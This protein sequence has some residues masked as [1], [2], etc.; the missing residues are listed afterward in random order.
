VSI[1]EPCV[2]FRLYLNEDKLGKVIRPSEPALIRT[3]SH[4]FLRLLAVLVTALTVAVALFAWRIASGPL[5]LDWLTPYVADALSSDDGRIRVAIGGTEL[6]L[7]DDI[8][9]V[10]L[11]VVDVRVTGE[12]GRPA[13]RLP[14]IEIALSLRA[15]LG[16]MV[17][18]ARLEATSPHLVLI[19]RDDGSIGL[20]G[21]EADEASGQVDM[22][23][24]ARQMLG[25]DPNDRAS[26]FEE[27]RIFGGSLT[28]VDQRT[29]HRL[30]A[31][32]AE[33]VL[34]RHQGGL[35]GSL[36]F[37]LLQSAQ[38][39]DVRLAGRYDAATEWID[40]GLDADRVMPSHFASLLPD[41]PLRGVAL[42]L[43]GRL[44]GRLKLDGERS[45][46]RFELAGGPG[47]VDLPDV[48]LAS[49]PIAAARADGEL[50]SDFESVVLNRFEVSAKDASLAGTGTLSWPE[51]QI[52]LD[53]E[54][55]ARNVAA[56]DLALFW[57][58]AAGDEARAWVIE[59][60]TDGIVPQAQAT[61][62]IR[63][64]DLDQRPVPESIVSG[65][66]EYD[67]LTVHYFEE[68]PPLTAVDGSAT[69]TARR[70]DFAVAGGRIGD[71]QV[72]DGSVVITGMG[73]PGRE[74]TQLEVATHAKGS[75]RD[76][77]T[78]IDHP[79][80]GF[81]AEA[82][83]S[84]ADVAGNA[85]IDLRIGLP[86]HRDVEDSEVRVAASAQL[87]GAALQGP[88]FRLED[89]RLSLTVDNEG[90]D[91]KGDALV[92]QIPLQVEF[93]D[94]FDDDA[95]FSRRYRVQGMVDHEAIA[96]L[97][98]DLP[99]EL[100]GALGLDATVV[101]KVGLREVEV[102]L[103]LAQLAITSPQ[104][105]WSKDVGEPGALD[106]S[107]VLPREGPIRVAALDMT[108]PSLE[109]SGSLQLQAE[110]LALETLV[111][112]RL[113]IGQTDGALS[114]RRGADQ[115]Y[116]VSLDAQSLDLG[117][118]LETDDAPPA[119]EAPVPV[120]VEARAQRALLNGHELREISAD[121][122]RDEQGWRSAW[123]NA[124]LP[125][126]GQLEVTLAPDGPVRRLHVTSSDAGALFEAADQTSRI[127]GGSLD[128]NAAIS[129]QHPAL[130]MEGTLRI[131]DF[132]LV[133]APLLARLLTV[134]SLTGIGNLLSGQGI[135]LNRFEMPF[136]YQERILA[137]DRVRLSGSQLGLTAKGTLD[138]ANDRID[139]S[140]T[141]VPIY[142]LNWAIGRIPIL[143]DFLRG[144]EGDG[145][146]A[147]TYSVSGAADDPRI[148]VN[149]LSVLAPGV[150]RELFSGIMQGTTT[151]PTVRGE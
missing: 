54:V 108:G 13:A 120:R 3:I 140:G 46:L 136:T 25:G 90:L 62:T 125:S 114:V 56:R 133:E 121:L 110:P 50:A 135:F 73:I 94:N 139:L 11:V 96:R 43:T 77:L 138:L 148:I 38:P 28:L 122:S 107:L 15:L 126:G 95:P 83:L 36:E 57:P 91:L 45:P 75:L 118:L 86:L 81:A 59:N 65:R 151:P 82:D 42:P 51:G 74:T 128:L 34:M 69:F 6:R 49:L 93:R 18:V 145:A 24:L 79:P 67:D 14:E 115:V 52:T 53:A 35:G 131:T 101:E 109:L 58:P 2:T 61:I 12:D 98:G 71:I 41:V 113:R 141:I 29:G 104:L 17:A 137:V 129:Q 146:F 85:D 111:L 16:G 80:L 99:L 143:G 134:A 116:E 64:G 88:Q 102:A 149:P 37:A 119:D 27:L 117:P 10:E 105:A 87:T 26:Y 1:P 39:A 130:A 23:H 124:L 44:T 7:S 70:M 8:D 103:D 142:G 63:P 112:E 40:F 30:R 72:G 9:L 89:G 132:T 92:E 60:I 19:R 97:A 68:L 47:H 144:S 84:P 21:T 48:L 100:R 76:V 31:R 4:R 66:F 5:A 55:E 22:R 20:R 127:A 32:Q 147:M 150:I 123:I 78:L 33:L 106:A